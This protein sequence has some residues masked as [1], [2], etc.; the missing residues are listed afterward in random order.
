M[1]PVVAFLALGSNLGDRSA[2]LAY[3]VEQLDAAPGVRVLRV[4]PPE[5]TEPLGNLDQPDYLNAMV[6]VEADIRARELLRLCADIERRAGRREHEHWASRELDIDI[7]RFGD[8]E[9]DDP[10][11]LLPHPGLQH[12]AFWK[13]QVAQLEEVLHG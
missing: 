4:T 9:S 5:V 8:E 1:N 7:V 6:A 11:L 2:M 10:S 13:R 12:R 3:A